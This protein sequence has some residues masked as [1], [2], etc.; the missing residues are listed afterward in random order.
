M[1]WRVRLSVVIDLAALS[2]IQPA[3]ISLLRQAGQSDDFLVSLLKPTALLKK[4]K[5]CCVDTSA[6]T[7]PRLPPPSDDDSSQ[8]GEVGSPSQVAD[9]LAPYLEAALSDDDLDVLP[10]HAPVLAR[11]HA[12]GPVS[13]PDGSLVPWD[14]EINFD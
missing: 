8:M 5:A 2:T 9:D 6:P 3:L 12:Q 13:V 10:N 11:V 1:A 4:S 14:A 7:G